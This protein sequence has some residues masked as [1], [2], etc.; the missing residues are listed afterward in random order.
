MILHGD[1]QQSTLLQI[2]IVFKKLSVK[3]GNLTGAEFITEDGNLVLGFP[4]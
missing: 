3:R 1:R 4:F 2:G